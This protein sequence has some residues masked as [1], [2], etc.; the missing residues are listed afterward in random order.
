MLES[1]TNGRK[2]DSV[3][4]LEFTGDYHVKKNERGE[5]VSLWMKLP[6]SGTRGRIAA[7]GFGVEGEDEW[8]ITEN[9][10][11]LVSVDPS[12]DEGMP[13][14]FHGHLIDGIWSW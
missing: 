13:E 7:Y 14:G 5:I 8:D 4:D 1:G 9:E 6:V 2:V 12:I 3:G 10:E 11:G